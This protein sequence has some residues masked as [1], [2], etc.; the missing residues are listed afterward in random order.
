MTRKLE[1]VK[2]INHDQVIENAIIEIN[3]SKISKITPIDGQAEHIVVP[4][5]IDVHIHG[6]MG[7]D[8]MEGKQAVE[9]ISSELKKV[10]TT[11]FLP[12]AMTQDVSIIK[13]ALKDISEAKSSGAKILGIHLEGPFISHEKKGA[14]DEQFLLKPTKELI[15]EFYEASNKTLKKMTI[16]PEL[17]SVDLL[18]HLTSLG[19]V[20][21]IGHTNGT[22]DDVLKAISG[23]ASSCTHL[24][25]AMTGVAN[26]TPGIVEGILLEENIYAELI[27]D[28]IHVDKEAINLSVKTKGTNRII[29]TT[30]ALKAAGMPDGDSIS[31]G[32]EVTK[33]GLYITLKGTNVLAG[34]GA[35]ML[36]NFKNLIKLRYDIKDVVAMTSY[37]AAKNLKVDLGQLKEGKEADLIIMDKNFNIKEVLV[38][39]E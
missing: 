28:L 23:G 4:G 5:F 39:G 8:N 21:S 11:S 38:K 34:S 26:R 35:T 6:F 22:S 7:K 25:N 15:D 20:G 16:A 14:H 32:L 36:D 18:K 19:I 37:N 3:G 2:I 17:F 10:G 31:G 9:Y 1:N 24:W 30:D 27:C 13:K 29:A 12:T 33:K